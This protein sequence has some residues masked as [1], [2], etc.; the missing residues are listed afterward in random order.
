VERWK[1][2]SGTKEADESVS[3]AIARHDTI[4]VVANQDHIRE[5]RVK[6]DRRVM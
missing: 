6:S 2:S 3:H 5:L 1:V 4:V